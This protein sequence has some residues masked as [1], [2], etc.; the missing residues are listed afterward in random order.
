MNI[1]LVI[2]LAL[3]WLGVMAFH[4]QA[5]GAELTQEQ[6]TLIYALAHSTSGYPFPE[7]PPTIHLVPQSKLQEMACPGKA[8]SVEGFSVGAD[9]YIDETLDMSNPYNGSILLHE[10]VHYLQFMKLGVAKTCEEWVDREWE[11]YAIQNH[12]LDKVG[13][14]PVIV[15][16]FS[17]L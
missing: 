14:R 7:K 1:R 2:G 11:A 15:P 13:A 17:C 6:A 4:P 9:I 8:C 12:A 3:I 16:A 10:A 5:R